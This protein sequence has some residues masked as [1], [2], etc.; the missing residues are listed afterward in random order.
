M[1]GL[2]NEQIHL[3]REFK[4]LEDQKMKLRE[5]S[6]VLESSNTDDDF[7]I[8]EDV[9]KDLIKKQVYPLSSTA[10]SVGQ[11]RK[12]PDYGNVSGNRNHIFEPETLLKRQKTARTPFILQPKS[13]QN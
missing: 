2:S 8:A 4:G 5:L 9:L 7:N 6:D 1:K 10:D 12:C 3:M 11:K 13:S